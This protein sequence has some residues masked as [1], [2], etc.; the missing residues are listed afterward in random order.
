MG[1]F[2]GTADY[3]KNIV[4]TWV[5][6]LFKNIATIMDTVEEEIDKIK[7]T[8]FD[9]GYADRCIRDIKAYGYDRLQEAISDA[10]FIGS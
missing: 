4:D 9:S 8:E 5:K 10:V 7:A 1:Y 6:N 2:T 3:M